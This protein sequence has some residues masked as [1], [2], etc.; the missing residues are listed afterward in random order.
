MQYTQLALFPDSAVV[1]TGRPH[2][3]PAAEEVAEVPA[4]AQAE[5]LFDLDIPAQDA[6]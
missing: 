5:V 1:G 2:P 6:A 4:P 3:W